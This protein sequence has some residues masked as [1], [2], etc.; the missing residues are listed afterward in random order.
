VNDQREA[1]DFKPSTMAHHHAPSQGIQVK[2]AKNPIIEG[3]NLEVL[4]LLQKSYSGCVYSTLLW[5][6]FISIGEFSSMQGCT[7]IPWNSRSRKR[8]Q[9]N[10]S[11]RRRDI[12]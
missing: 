10:A 2:D 5:D 3:E 1:R 11:I 7:W 8:T 12:P 4:P 9:L 6:E